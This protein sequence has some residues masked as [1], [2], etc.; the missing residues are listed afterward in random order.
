VGVVA[1]LAQR[2]QHRISYEDQREARRG[3][4]TE[5]QADLYDEYVTEPLL[6]LA[7]FGELRADELAE[8]KAKADEARPRIGTGRERIGSGGVDRAD[9]RR[10]RLWEAVSAAM[11]AVGYSGRPAA[12]NAP[13]LDGKAAQ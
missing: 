2:P 7:S 1:L 8:L 10:V 6:F 5:E 13:S 9:R 12:S 3:K 11:E 4:S